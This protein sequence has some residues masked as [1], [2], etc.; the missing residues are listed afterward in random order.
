MGWNHIWIW[1]KKTLFFVENIFS[2]CIM[3][4]TIDELVQVAKRL[5]WE[6]KDLHYDVRHNDKLS[7]FFDKMRSLDDF[8][9]I[10]VVH[11]LTDDD[12]LYQLCMKGSKSIAKGKPRRIRRYLSQLHEQSPEIRMIKSRFNMSES[13]GRTDPETRV[14]L[15]NDIVRSIQ[16][17]LK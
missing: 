10:I 15:V 14:F 9:R 2:Y 4:Q 1:N 8:Q 16:K 5:V 7:H 13:S 3:R 11:G 12:P 6:V 17:L